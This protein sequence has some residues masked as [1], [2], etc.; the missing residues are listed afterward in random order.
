MC[1]FFVGRCCYFLYELF[2]IFLQN[3]VL[4]LLCVFDEG[5]V[6]AV[7]GVAGVVLV[8]VF[9]A[10]GDEGGDELVERGV[11]VVH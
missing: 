7:L 8:A 10:F 2:Q 11:W 3:D 4:L 1:V 5:L 9:P 6:G